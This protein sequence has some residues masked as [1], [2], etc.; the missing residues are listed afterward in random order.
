MYHCT[1]FSSCLNFEFWK[2]WV[3]LL[4]CQGHII[5]LVAVF[6]VY[7]PI[8]IENLIENRENLCESKCIDFLIVINNMHDH[9]TGVDFFSFCKIDDCFQRNHCILKKY[10]L[11]TVSIGNTALQR[12]WFRHVTLQQFSFRWAGYFQV[13]SFQKDYTF[14]LLQTLLFS[15]YNKN[16]YKISPLGMSPLNRK[17]SW[18]GYYLRIA[19]DGS[20]IEIA[21][22]TVSGVFIC[23]FTKSQTKN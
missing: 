23:E 4:L 12:F 2:I 10:Y 21:G 13:G 7:R 5:W 9:T 14:W 8:R 18:W 15:G 1:T 19:R 22:G 3:Q 11:D 20:G 17:S 6:N 16:K